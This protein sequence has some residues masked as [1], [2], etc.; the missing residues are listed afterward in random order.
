M[1]KKIIH[2][3]II[4]FVL[5]LFTSLR[6]FAQDID[7]KV[8]EVIM[9]ESDSL[10]SKAKATYLLKDYSSILLTKPKTITHGFIGE[11]YQ[12]IDIIIL[13]AKQN[14]KTN[15]YIV[16]G[17]SRT[18]NIVSNFNGILIPTCIYTYKNL[19]FGVDNSFKNNGIKE[20][21]Y[22]LGKYKLYEDSTKQNS[23]FFEGTFALK[24]FIDKDSKLQYDD[25]G[26][27]S[28]EYWNNAFVGKWDKYN[29]NISEIC[30]WGD[31]RILFCGDLDC[32][33]GEF[34]PCEKYLQYGWDTYSRA[35]VNNDPKAREYEE[36]KWW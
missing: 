19:H 24:W 20:Q 36:T 27:V 11:N 22:L 18:N 26:S 25:I 6:V 21:G 29:S 13:S 33:A 23:G 8:I 3:K 10:I 28:D 5:T 7:K 31:Y 2:F 34:S 9:Y 12:R 14:D 4:F 16:M 17:K 30:N 15:E 35:Y 32:G 1:I